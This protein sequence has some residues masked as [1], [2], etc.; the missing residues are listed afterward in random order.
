MA[1]TR[2]QRVTMWIIIIVLAGGT[3][4]SFFA[5]ILSNSNTTK[6]QNKLSQEYQTYENQ[7]NR[8]ATEWSNKYYTTFVKYKSL[9]GSFSASDAQKALAHT[10]LVVGTTG[11]AISEDSTYAAYYIGWTPNGQIFDSSFDSKG[12]ALK[13]PL[14]V[15]PDSVI[16]G[17][18]SGTT[19]MK[20]G[21]VREITIPSEQAYGSSGNGSSIP[22]NTPIKFVIMVVPVPPTITMPA[23][24]QQALD[25]E[26][27]G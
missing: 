18:I 22:A 23:D 19:G 7:V 13:A 27:E 24:L 20:I 5:I 1:T 21:G 3:F 11:P 9:V 14:T 17:W 6:Q 12:A 26:Q 25:S 15:T 8:Q 10:D 16:S 2:K 4:M